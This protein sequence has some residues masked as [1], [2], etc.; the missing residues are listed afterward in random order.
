MENFKDRNYYP[1]AWNK[2]CVTSTSNSGSVITNGANVLNNKYAI[3]YKSVDG[4]NIGDVGD[5]YI[6]TGVAFAVGVIPT[7]I[8]DVTTG[9]VLEQSFYNN[10]EL[11]FK[12]IST[13]NTDGQLINFKIV[14][15]AGIE[16]KAVEI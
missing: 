8:I 7:Q 16:F 1:V 11:V 10:L 9:N 12:W 6:G 3:L 15:A 2:M 13:Y 5:I 4:D 14:N